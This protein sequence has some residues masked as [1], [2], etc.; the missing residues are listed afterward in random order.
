MG[1]TG[2]IED[3]A[4]SRE[5]I[6]SPVVQHCSPNVFVLGAASVH[7]IYPHVATIAKIKSRCPLMSLQVV[8][9]HVKARTMTRIRA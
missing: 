9:G 2:E 3:A 7:L 4:I 8:V 6:I 1:E 5:I